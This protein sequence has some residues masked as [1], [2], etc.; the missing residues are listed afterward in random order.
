MMKK[1]KHLFL[2]AIS[3]SVLLLCM[4]GCSEKQ[5]TV[6]E[7]EETQTEEEN[8][9]TMYL[10]MEHDVME[11]K[12]ILYSYETGLEH[13]FQYDV[14]TRFKNKYGDYI[15]STEFVPGRIVK[16]GER[17]LDGALSEMQISDAVWEY[18]DVRRFSIDSEEGIL[19][20][21]GTNYSIRD[22]YYVFSNG[23]KIHASQIS[24]DDVLTVIGLDKKVLSVI[25]TTGHGRLAL[26]NTE[27]FE[28]SFLQLNNDVFSIITENMEMELAEGTYI[29][30]VAND[31][32]GG[33]KE[34]EIVRDETTE[35]DL[36]ELKG[37]GKKKGTVNFDINADDVS[38]YVDYELV[39]HTQK[40]ELT[41][42][43]HVIKIEAEGY[44]TWKKYLSVN[45]PNSTIVIELET[46]TAAEMENTTENETGSETENET[47]TEPETESETQTE[48]ET[49]TP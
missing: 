16:V 4:T 38:V 18:E 12:V 9:E 7:T 47:E 21:A 1:I 2:C 17:R 41:Y 46:D 19:D 20:I 26:K 8:A 33:S 25:V 27:S 28:G 30:K 36:N 35:V 48:T 32:W 15:P 14:L 37:E 22:R 45:S 24:E 39:D 34:I 3:L 23:E 42:G 6:A 5:Q 29:L 11:E 13:Y 44:N 43:V 40:L 10:I 49:Q 31:G